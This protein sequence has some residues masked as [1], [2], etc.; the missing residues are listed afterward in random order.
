M[1]LSD[2]Q[3]ARPGARNGIPYRTLGAPR[4]AFLFRDGLGAR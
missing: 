3:E 1:G 4:W 2:R